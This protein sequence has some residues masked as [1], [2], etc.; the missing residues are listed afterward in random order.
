V[1]R[2]QVTFEDVGFT[3]DQA[4]KDASLSQDEVA[5]FNQK[6]K[7]AK[8]FKRPVLELLGAHFAEDDEQGKSDIKVFLS[9]DLL[10]DTSFIEH[11]ENAAPP[12]AVLTEV[13]DALLKKAKKP[14]DLQ[15]NWEN[16]MATE[17]EEIAADL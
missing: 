6:A 7:Q 11:A 13:Q 14:V 5:K 8:L 2:F 1:A 16:V 10:L 12:T 15:G 17:P 9:V 4:L 3:D